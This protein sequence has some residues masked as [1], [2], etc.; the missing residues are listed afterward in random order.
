M[1]T[2]EQRAEKFADAFVNAW[3]GQ[4]T[5]LR[6]LAKDSYKQGAEEALCS[7]WVSVK[8]GLPDEGVDVLVAYRNL[9][10]DHIYYS[11]AWTGKDGRWYSADDDVEPLGIVAWM[12]IPEYQGKE[13][14]NE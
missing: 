11:L 2:I 14:D 6:R 8:D 3:K 7:Q 5:G 1:K 9:I 12:P 4:P 10:T 13:A